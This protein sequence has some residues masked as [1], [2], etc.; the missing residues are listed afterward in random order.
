MVLNL[1]EEKLARQNQGDEGGPNR[2]RVTGRA[3]TLSRLN[4]LRLGIG[5][6]FA[7]LGWRLWDMQINRP[8]EARNTTQQEIRPIKIKAPRGIIYDANEQKLVS[9]KPTYSVT[10]TRY[11]L[12]KLVDNKDW[13]KDERARQK[14]LVTLQRQAVFDSLARFLVMDYVVGVVPEQ[15]FGDPKVAAAGEEDQNATLNALERLLGRAAIDVK[16]DLQKARKQDLYVFPGRIQLNDSRFAD[17]LKLRERK[18][19]FFLSEAERVVFVSTFATAD[20]EPVVV[21]SGLNREDAMLLEEKRLDLPGVGIQIGYVREYSDPKLFAHILGYNGYFRSEESREAANKEA[22][23][24][25][26]DTVNP[27]NPINSRVVYDPDDK[28]GLAG[29]EAQFEAYLRGQKGG[30]DVVVDSSGH[31]IETVKDSER[32]AL[33]GNSVYL[34]IRGDL[35]KVVTAALDKQISEANKEK[36]AGVSEGAAVVMD[37]TNGQVLA[38]VAFPYY[39]NNK[40]SGRLTD[41]DVKALFDPEKAPLVN[42]A[43]SARYAPGSTFKLITALCGLGEGNIDSNRTYNCSQFIDIPT[44]QVQ[45][46]QEFRC[47]GKH[48][49]V[50][51]VGAVEQSCDIFFYN[52]GVAGESNEFFG[53]NRY[54]EKGNRKDANLFRG[55]GIEA[56]NKYMDMFGLGKPTGIELP[57]EYNGNLPTRASHLRATGNPWSV[58]DTMTTSIGQG[59]VE[60]TPLQVCN[61]TATIANGGTLYQPTILKEVRDTKRNVVKAFEKIKLRDLPVSPYHLQLVRQGM[62]NVTAPRGTAS[63]LAGQLGRLQVAGKTGTAEYGEIYGVDPETKL[64]LRAT[65]AW[66]TAYAPYDK[67]K[68]AVTVLIAAGSRQI[69]GSTFAVPAAK[70]ILTYLFPD[71][72]KVTKA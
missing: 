30:R 70:D 12:P 57:N 25:Y 2:N 41:G 21:A 17:F 72:T 3:Q 62:L 5:G 46:F 52:V 29:V 15:F 43:I 35:Q 37:V 56:I 9:N 36:S 58:G 66:F 39:D 18:G 31:I 44:T 26:I 27:D 7:I 60:M 4:F 22:A 1:D 63:R 45:Q 65:H 14:D 50:N 19:V 47:W 23:K 33:A 61:M 40:F 24:D 28:V 69:E 32:E 64:P 48:G 13:S 49:S 68:Y 34:T 71:E 38:L 8:P 11:D 42:R 16:K 6:S 10:L 55:V 51:V 53:A 59:E 20:Y 54:Y 67:P